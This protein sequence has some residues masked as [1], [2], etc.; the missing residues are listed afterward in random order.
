MPVMPIMGI[1]GMGGANGML[2]TTTGES[3]LPA[4]AGAGAP[5]AS[6]TANM[7]SITF[8]LPSRSDSLSV[9]RTD[10]PEEEIARD[11]AKRHG[12]GM[13]FSSVANA[14]LAAL[15]WR[16]QT[17]HQEDLEVSFYLYIFCYRLIFI[18]IFIISMINRCIGATIW[19]LEWNI[20][21][22]FS[23]TILSLLLFFGLY[24]YY[25]IWTLVIESCLRSL[26]WHNEWV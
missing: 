5:A 24:L 26:W 7:P 15:A 21:L 2:I 10:A 3:P 23:S 17:A 1:P 13:S 18:N 11:K 6:P 9:M 14:S 12:G 20:V 22:E 16:K 25:Y 19:H 4:T 8:N